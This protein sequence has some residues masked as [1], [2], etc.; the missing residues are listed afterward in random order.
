MTSELSQLFSLQP[1]AHAYNSNREEEYA[2]AQRAAVEATMIGRETLETAVRQGEQLQNAETLADETEYK[3]D[4]AARVL[5]G[6]T[7]TGWWANKFSRDIEPPDIKSMH[8]S[9]T[10][11]PPKVYDDVPRPCAAAAQAVQNYHAN[12]QVLET[13]ETSDQRETCK[14]ICDN[15]YQT[16][17][18]EVTALHR[19]QELAD[20][21]LQGF[22]SR[23]GKD[24]EILRQRQQQTEGGLPALSNPSN[25]PAG[26]TKSELFGNKSESLV[27]SSP[28]DQVQ[29]Q[30]DHHLDFIS[31]HLDE[32]GS[33]ASNLNSSLALHSDTL[34]S[35]DGKSESML[36]KS[37]MVTRRA[38]RLIQTKSWTKPKSEFLFTASIRHVA[39]GKFIAI[40]SSNGSLILQD[41][42]NETCLFGIWQRQTGAKVFGWQ[43]KYSNRWVGQSLLG[44]LVCSAYSF[45]RREE[46]DADSDDWSH[47]PLLCASAGWGNGAYLLVRKEDLVLTLGSG[48]VQDKKNAD[49]WCIQEYNPTA[50]K[51]TNKSQSSPNKQPRP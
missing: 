50:G 14:V 29:L 22:P 13:C 15:M 33:L 42:M 26:N 51:T 30:Q 25:P 34:E 31:R 36:Y 11:P 20:E 17:R 40:S 49:I 41:K 7:W 16:A 1:Q 2:A 47:T 4:R 24:L 38:D 44:S 10:M 5:R 23:L 35:L 37:K 39:T 19:R 28:V 12:V 3:L 8:S 9:G 21:D 6:M 27:T 45:D 46:W 43:S 48:G 32:L 18:R